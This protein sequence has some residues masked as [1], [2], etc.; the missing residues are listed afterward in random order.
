MEPSDI[1]FGL[2]CL[3]SILVL[4]VILDYIIDYIQKDGKE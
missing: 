1:Y 2:V 3:A 4:A